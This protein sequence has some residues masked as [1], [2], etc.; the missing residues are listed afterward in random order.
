[1]ASARTGM[2]WVFAFV[3]GASACATEPPPPPS[4][5]T[6]LDSQV[7]DDRL[8]TSLASPL[9]A[10]TVTFTGT[11]VTVNS[12]PPRLDKWI[13]VV[14][15]SD[16]EIEAV[17]D[18]D[19]VVERSMAGIAITLAMTSYKMVADYVAY[20]PVRDFDVHIYYAPKSA[21]VTRVLFTRR[22]EEA[23]S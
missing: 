19:L 18:P 7:F 9:D 10:V 21:L 12:I 22:V 17:P 20:Q 6:F 11:D 16:G 1:M 4:K 15:Q 23:G 2:V 5:L 13:Y 3:L 14:A 8:R